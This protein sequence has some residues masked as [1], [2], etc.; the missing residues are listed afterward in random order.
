[1]KRTAQQ[2]CI[3]DLCD[4]CG[5]EDGFQH[6]NIQQCQTCGVCVHE[7][8]YGLTNS[9]SMVKYQQWKCAPC[10]AI[11]LDL[12]VNKPTEPHR[13]ISVTSRNTECALCC[14]TNGIHAMHLLYDTHGKD[15]TPVILPQNKRKGLEERVAWV[16]TLCALFIGDREKV[17]FGCKNDGSYLGESDDENEDEDES[18]DDNA[19]TNNTLEV[20]NGMNLVSSN[21]KELIILDNPHHFVVSNV[22]EDGAEDDWSRAVRVLKEARYKCFICGLGN[23][24]KQ[25]TLAIPCCYKDCTQCFHIGCA[26]WGKSSGHYERIL[27]NPGAFND[28][29]EDYNLATALGY[30]DMHSKKQH[31]R[32]VEFFENGK[33]QKERKTAKQSRTPLDLMMIREN[34]SKQK[35]L[36]TSLLGK[37]EV[38]DEDGEN[39]Q[40]SKRWSHLWVPNYKPDI[41]YF[42]QWDNV[43]EITQEDME[44]WL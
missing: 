19:D 30:C 15:G 24:L 20:K 22:G 36:H 11:G 33:R 44:G 12:Q 14:V 28:S 43:K 1:M 40:L 6:M 3:S 31:L 17:V 41:G 27:F 32:S 38:A 4:V 21:G 9:A 7:T 13:S 39:K 42:S 10:S 25:N 37:A 26:R 18:D 8:C 29:E 34:H 23:G 35:D 16:H 5:R 2:I